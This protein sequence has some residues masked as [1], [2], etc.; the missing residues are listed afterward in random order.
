MAS[1]DIR[2]ILSD[3]NVFQKC[4]KKAFIDL[5]IRLSL[6]CFAILGM[7]KAS[8]WYEFLVFMSVYGIQI[9]FL[10][11]GGYAHELSHYTVFKSPTINSIIFKI[12]SVINFSNYSYYRISHPLHHRH[13]LDP[14]RDPEGKA[15]MSMSKRQFMCSLTLDVPLLIRDLTILSQNAM[16]KVHQPINP[17]MFQTEKAISSIQKT[18]LTII[19]AH[20][21]VSSV[22]IYLSTPEI[23]IAQFL[24]PYVHTIWNRVAVAS[25]HMSFPGSSDKVNDLKLPSIMQFLYANMNYHSEHHEYISI[26]FYNLPTAR[27]IINPESRLI[28]ISQVVKQMLSNH[29]MLRST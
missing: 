16:G 27:K 18:A 2:K 13:M 29:S 19:V 11:W 28:T 23:V 26:P 20:I 6:L 17:S 7:V 9:R 12:L 14:S 25:Q 4:D 21:C 1:K 15:R 22:C 3:N 10:G 8:G 24:G 5:A